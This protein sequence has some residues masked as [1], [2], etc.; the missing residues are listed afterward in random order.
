VPLPLLK[1][2]DRSRDTLLENT[3]RFAVGLPANNALLWGAR[4]MGKSSLVKAR[5]RRS[6]P[7]CP[8]GSPGLKLIEIHREDIETLPELMARLRNRPERFIL[9]CDDLSFDSGDTSYK[10]LKAA[11]DGGVE[12]GRETSCS[13]RPPTAAT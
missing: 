9:F 6:P 4:G 13:M 1:G 2:I 11:L 8:A 10:S 3:R 12:G 7:R 5:M